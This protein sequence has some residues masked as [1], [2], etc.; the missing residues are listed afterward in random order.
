MTVEEYNKIPLN[1][2]ILIKYSY[3]DEEDNE[4]ISGYY[5][6]NKTNEGPDYYGRYVLTEAAGEQYA[7]NITGVED[8]MLC[9]ELDELFE[10]RK[11]TSK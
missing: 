2:D 7:V 3:K 4:I 6:V 1:E 8:W 11:G 10:K 5:V 9:K